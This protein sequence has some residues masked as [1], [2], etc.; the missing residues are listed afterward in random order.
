MPDGINALPLEY[1]QENCDSEFC[2]TPQG[3]GVYIPATISE[4]LAIQW[5]EHLSNVDENS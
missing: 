1:L 3:S 4:R 5:Y 2:W